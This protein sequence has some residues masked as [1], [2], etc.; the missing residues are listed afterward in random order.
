MD[1]TKQKLPLFSLILFYW[2]FTD[3]YY[4]GRYDVSIDAAGIFSS[5]CM[6]VVLII[7]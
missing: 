1:I 7:S 6:H 5:T 3:F 2:Y 4:F